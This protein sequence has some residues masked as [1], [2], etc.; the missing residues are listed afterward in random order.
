[1]VRVGIVGI[2]FMGMIHYLAWQK[3]RGARVGAI[4]TR[5]R[6]KLAGDWR[7]IQGNFGPPGSIMDLGGVAT[8]P[9]WQAM[10][11]DPKIDLIDICLPP[12]LHSELALAALKA[13]K[14][15]LVEKPIAV[16][17]GEARKMVQAADRSGKLL[18]VAHVL[19][20]IPEYAYARKL[21]ET[22]KYGKLLGGQFKRVISEPSWLKDFFDPRQ[23]GGPLVDLHIH[24]AHFI[25][26]ACGMPRALFS[27]GRMRGEVAEMFST[28]FLYDG[29]AVTASGGVIGQQ[30]RSF[31]H[32]FEIYLERA[33]LLYDSAVIEGQAV[34]GM[35]LTVLGP[36]GKVV[37]PELGEVD[38][39]AD[40]LAEAARSVRTGQ[41]SP[42]LAGSLACE[43]LELCH[44]Q[45]QSIRSGKIVRI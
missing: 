36:K 23:V 10:L 4:S 45:T 34:T 9:D 18:L 13:K 41:I 26:L 12:A 11:A 39:F 20:F 2:G 1:M 24:D 31:T 38:A 29:M 33:T 6:K 35:P 8:Y 21:I 5:D 27:T 22:G 44:L 40:E 25:R 16:A 7:G 15:V 28:Q 19:P 30:G 43:A 14:H 17:L 42:L 37:R 32:A 3:V